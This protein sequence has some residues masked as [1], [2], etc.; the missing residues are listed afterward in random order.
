MVHIYSSSLRK[1]A[2]THREDDDFAAPVFVPDV[3]H[4]AAA[5]FAQR[6]AC[7][8]LG[9]QQRTQAV[10]IRDAVAYRHGDGD[11]GAAQLREQH[12]SK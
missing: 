4:E 8:G 7:S 2:W 12:Q 5:S 10:W 11:R 3:V 6:E 9:A 1:G